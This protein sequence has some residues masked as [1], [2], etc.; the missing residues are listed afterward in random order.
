MN[1]NYRP[2]PHHTPPPSR[3]SG[4]AR[5]NCK[6][7]PVDCR[8]N[9]TPSVIIPSSEGARKRGLGSNSKRCLRHPPTTAVTDYATSPGKLLANG[10]FFC[11]WCSNGSTF[12]RQTTQIRPAFW[13]LITALVAYVATQMKPKSFKQT[14]T[15]FS[16]FF[17]PGRTR[18]MLTCVLGR[19][20]AS[21]VLFCWGVHRLSLIHI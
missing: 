4:D 19:C 14:E 2:T 5:C 20:V 3:H 13:P 6:P 17:N 15:K 18:L 21:I 11:C 1:S 16:F 7:P 12:I 9:Q 10:Q 8:P